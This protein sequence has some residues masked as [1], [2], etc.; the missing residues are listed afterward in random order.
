MLFETSKKLAKLTWYDRTKKFGITKRD[1]LNEDTWYKGAYSKVYLTLKTKHDL[2][3]KVFYFYVSG[4]SE[5]E[6]KL[7]DDVWVFN[8]KP[9]F[10]D[11]DEQLDFYEYLKA[12]V[13]ISLS[14]LRLNVDNVYMVGPSGLVNCKGNID[15]TPIEDYYIKNR[16]YKRNEAYVKFFNMVDTLL[17]MDEIIDRATV[18]TEKV[19]FNVPFFDSNRLLPVGFG[20]HVIT[21][22]IRKR[23]YGSFEFDTSTLKEERLTQTSLYMPDKHTLKNFSLNPF[24][25]SMLYKAMLDYFLI[26]G[27]EK[28]LN[29]FTYDKVIKKVQEDPKLEYG[30]Y[31]ET[32]ETIVEDGGPEG[33]IDRE[34]KRKQ[35]FDELKAN[36]QVDVIAKAKL[37]REVYI[38]KWDDEKGWVVDEEH[39]KDREVVRPSI[40]ITKSNDEYFGYKSAWSRYHESC[41][42]K[43]CGGKE[44]KDRTPDEVVV[45]NVSG[46]RVLIPI[47]DKEVLLDRYMIPMDRIPTNEYYIKGNY[48]R[49]EKRKAI[50]AFLETYLST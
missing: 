29:E 13:Q 32:E 33:S 22:L 31:I 34:E 9:E 24:R 50:N 7:L 35:M 44:P 14:D 47:K 2:D 49:K 36:A 1:W 25:R 48:K 11:F 18:D 19:V 26:H 38:R 21:S 43:V 10:K 23:K 27:E 40:Q 17:D 5:T 3:N 6:D 30:W 16:F 8:D 39:E 45:I 28:T 41:I 12:L 42:K 37:K 15:K 46:D 4:K 20:R